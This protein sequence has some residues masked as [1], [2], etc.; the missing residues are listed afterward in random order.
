MASG[1][2]PPRALSFDALSLATV[3]EPKP[4][5]PSLI[6][7]GPVV[8]SLPLPVPFPPPRMPLV[9]AALPSASRV[10]LKIELAAP[11]LLAVPVP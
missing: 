5:V 1:P 6:S 11:P 2:S 3:P 4:F 9:A 10:A 7:E 8:P